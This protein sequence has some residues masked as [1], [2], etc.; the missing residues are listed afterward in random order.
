M[1]LLTMVLQNIRRRKLR[2]GILILS[3][4]I[5]VASIIF[6]S[7]TTQAMKKDVANQLD[8]FGSNIL[9]LPD[10]G[11]ALTFGGI[12]VE[13]PSQVKNLDMSLIPLMQTIKNKETLATIAPKLLATINL[14][15]QDILAIGVDFPAELKLKKW[16]K[17]D[18][19]AKNRLPNKDEIILGSDVALAL[20]LSPKQ[21]VV[22]KGQEF[23]IAGIIQPTG[24]AENDQAVF[25]DL[26]VLQA[27]TNQ[28][29]AISL[30]ETAA[31]C[32]SC[33]IEEVTQQ[34]R[35]KLPGTKITALQS[36]IKSRDDT[37]TK[38]NALTWSV[39]LTFLITCALILAITMKS[40]VEERTREI[41]ILRAIGFRKSHIV[42]II[43]GEA[44]LLSVSG[45]LLGYGLGMSLAVN[46]GAKLLKIQVTIPWQA[47]LLIYSTMAALIISLLS[48][49]YPAWKA[50]RLDPAE[51]LRYL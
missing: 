33:P 3:I 45:G 37:V 26:S 16:W 48:S 51:S 47:D 30:I 39:S 41:G 40:S 46:F 36:T 27:L 44:S 43:L 23:Q 32:Y 2:S 12:T 6:L 19:L 21:S 49:L 20:G 9:I 35:E 18:T 28:P 34:L 11:Q 8:E 1:H 15:G 31:L 42:R 25:M 38:F 22:I 50:A 14:Q 13:A 7:T 5:G 17:I 10:T 24:S 4:I 29:K